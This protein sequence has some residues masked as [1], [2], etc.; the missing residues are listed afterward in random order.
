MQNLPVVIYGDGKQVRDALYIDDL[1][2]A[3]DAAIDSIT[4]TAGQVYNI[5][6]GPQN[7][8]SILELIHL[9]NQQFDRR[10][11]YS[12]D[13]W[14]PGD[15]RIFVSDIQKAKRDFGWEPRVSIVQGI[16]RLVSWLKQHERMFL[17]T[18]TQEEINKETL[19]IST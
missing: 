18:E 3:Y 17:A 6:G 14:R 5:G 4:I 19:S 9:L 16:E 7:T 11:E 1:I 2:R 15:Q 8:L 13:A 12:F 10:L